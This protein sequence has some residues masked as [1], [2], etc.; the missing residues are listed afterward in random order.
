MVNEEILTYISDKIPVEILKDKPFIKGPHIVA[1]KGMI[2]RE[3]MPLTHRDKLCFSMGKE[4]HDEGSSTTG[5]T[6]ICNGCG[7]P[8]SW[9]GYFCVLCGYF[10]IKDFAHPKFCFAYPTC[11]GCMPQL[12]WTYCTGHGFNNDVRS[13]WGIVPPT[14]VNP[15]KY[16][17]EDLTN[18]FD[19]D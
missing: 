6:P 14:G 10:F 19:F 18:V 7:K 9:F 16:T 17:A 12:P 11:W 8:Y 5:P 15:K 3:S 13:E 1:L 2:L 4:G